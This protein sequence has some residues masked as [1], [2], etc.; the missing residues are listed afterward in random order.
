MSIAYKPIQQNTRRPEREGGLSGFLT[1]KID[2]LQSFF[3]KLLIKIKERLGVQ[4]S[5]SYSYWKSLIRLASNPQGFQKAENLLTEAIN[6]LSS[7]SEYPTNIAYFI[8]F[9]ANFILDELK[10]NNQLTREQKQ[11]LIDL[12]RTLVSS[13]ELQSG[14]EIIAQEFLSAEEASHNTTSLTQVLEDPVIGINGKNVDEG[15][16]WFDKDGRTPFEQE[17]KRLFTTKAWQNASPETRLRILDNCQRSY[18]SLITGQKNQGQ[19]LIT[20]KTRLLERIESQF[21]AERLRVFDSEEGKTHLGEL[22]E[23]GENSLI[24]YFED[25]KNQLREK[26][27]RKGGEVDLTQAIDIFKDLAVI[28]SHIQDEKIKAY[29]AYQIDRVFIDTIRET[30]NKELKDAYIEFRRSYLADIRKT[31]GILVDDEQIGIKVDEIVNNLFDSI[32]GIGGVCDLSDTVVEDVKSWINYLVQKG[33][34]DQV[35]H[36]FQEIVSTIFFDYVNED[37]LSKGFKRKIKDQQQADKISQLFRELLSLRIAQQESKEKSEQQQKPQS[38]LSIFLDSI[39]YYFRN[40]EEPAEEDVDTYA[41][42][43]KSTRS[44]LAGDDKQELRKQLAIQELKEQFKISRIRYFWNLLIQFYD[45]RQGIDLSSAGDEIWTKLKEIFGNIDDPEFLNTFYSIGKEHLMIALRQAPENTKIKEILSE[46]LGIGVNLEGCEEIK[47]ATLN[48]NRQKDFFARAREYEATKIASSFEII[49]SGNFVDKDLEEIFNFLFKEVKKPKDNQNIEDYISSLPFPDNLKPFVKRFLQWR[50]SVDPQF[51]KQSNQLITSFKKSALGIEL[52]KNIFFRKTYW[53]PYLEAKRD[54]KLQDLRLAFEK[55]MWALMSVLAESGKMT[56]EQMIEF[57]RAGYQELILAINKEKDIGLK[58]QMTFEIIRLLTSSP[59]AYKIKELEKDPLNTTGK[60]SLTLGGLQTEFVKVAVGNKLFEDPEAVKE[61]QKMMGLLIATKVEKTTEELEFLIMALTMYKRE[62]LRVEYEEGN[63]ENGNTEDR[64][65]KE[66]PELSSFRASFIATL[67]NLTPNLEKSDLHFL[68]W[69]SLLSMISPLTFYRLVLYEDRAQAT[70]NERKLSEHQEKL[71][72]SIIS[73][74]KDNR[75]LAFY[76]VF[77][78]TGKMS[79]GDELLKDVNLSSELLEKLKGVVNLSDGRSSLQYALK[80]FDDICRLTDIPGLGYL[81]LEEASS[82]QDLIRLFFNNSIDRIKRFLDLKGERSDK[83]RKFAV[84]ELLSLS[85]MMEETP[86]E[87]SELKTSEYA[88]KISNILIDILTKETPDSYLYQIAEIILRTSVPQWSIENQKVFVD[89]LF[90]KASNEDTMIFE[91]HWKNILDMLAIKNSSFVNIPQNK[92]EVRE[93]IAKYIIDKTIEVLSKYLRIGGRT[94]LRSLY[95]ILTGE[96]PPWINESERNNYLLFPVD[97]QGK[98]I[99]GQEYD[100][101][102]NFLHQAIGMTSRYGK[103]EQKAQLIITI[104]ELIKEELFI[105]ASKH[106]VRLDLPKS[107][108]ELNTSVERIAQMLKDKENE[109]F[110]KLIKGVYQLTNPIVRVDKS[111]GISEIQE[112]KLLSII[113]REAEKKEQEANTKLDEIKTQYQAVIQQAKKQ[114]GQKINWQ[115]VLKEIIEKSEKSRGVFSID[116]DRL[117]GFLESISAQ[118]AEALRTAFQNI[119]SDSTSGGSQQAGGAKNQR[120]INISYSELGKLI[121]LFLT[122]QGV[123]GDNIGTVI[124]DVFASQ[125]RSTQFVSNIFSQ[126]GLEQKTQEEKRKVMEEMTRVLRAFV[127][128]EAELV[129]KLNAVLNQRIELLGKIVSGQYQALQG[130]EENLLEKIKKAAEEE[131]RMIY[132]EITTLTEQIRSLVEARKNI[133]DKIFGESGESSK[134]SSVVSEEMEKQISALRE[135]IQSILNFIDNVQRGRKKQENDEGDAETTLP[136][137]PDIR[138][139][140]VEELVGILGNMH[141]E[142]GFRININI[143]N[144]DIKYQDVLKAL[145]IY[146]LWKELLEQIGLITASEEQEGTTTSE[147]QQ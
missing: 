35:F 106:A 89:T 125:E 43:L 12:Y 147:Q 119:S 117:L 138:K 63:N 15:A 25:L 121:A 87:A 83:L 90:Y 18:Q 69:V 9:G 14:W 85:M 76:K 101:S 65:I 71:I 61:L 64:K 120:T 47:T 110:E 126:L 112:P 145:G 129:G 133:A 59:L 1:P 74:N 48:Y 37:D 94:H 128:N 143:A 135:D 23:K 107:R 20:R 54:R 122:Q 6:G 29:F 109:A 123:L 111:G 108:E 75:L 56:T 92:V 44:D 142:D 31:A 131:I 72:Q 8:E 55:E 19:Y 81:F 73:K 100:S 136:S 114:L 93:E 4:F 103:D 66:I 16:L 70:K 82:Q 113:R 139:K 58:T 137:V 27:R 124:H 51:N 79:G 10:K 144:L 40:Q 88:S 97:E 41:E 49:N 67:E 91:K 34:Q 13:Q 7:L 39:K 52:A 22:L 17:F 84:Y 104:E 53:R 132:M 134:N 28:I 26:A 130:L 24:Q 105:L 2:K 95:N 5:D 62:K 11:G 38:L 118:G 33:K 42:Q 127:G 98:H 50:I 46:L 146:D 102:S 115:E 30:E 116:V 86:F 77:L 45:K 32:I 99:E 36:L 57:L 80:W 96:V 21:F 68:E 140:I 78:Q 60:F 3:E 141:K